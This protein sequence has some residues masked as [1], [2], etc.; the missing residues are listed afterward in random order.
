M[1]SF[2]V[3][4]KYTTSAL[5]TAAANRFSFVFMITGKLTRIIL[6][7][8]FL[9]FIFDG[10][11]TLAG[12]TKEQIIFFYL[13]FNLLDT[14]SQLFFREVYRFR[15]L[16]VTGNLDLVLVKPINPLIRVLLGG[17]D[18]L[19]GI[20]LVLILGAILIYG[21]LYITQNIYSWI[22]YFVLVINGLVISGAFYMLVL[23]LGVI[24]TS[25]DH[26]AM[27]YRD[28]TSMLRIPADLYIQP[29]RFLITFAIPLGVMLTFPPQA[30]MGILS[31]QNILLSFAISITTFILSYK[32]WQYSLKHYQSASS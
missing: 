3:W 11:R 2:K 10:T 1:K 14:L 20:V 26:L 30:L 12:Y 5:Q 6:F 13:S 17:F 31:V 24:T 22:I 23:G 25:V 4:L 27:V 9:N 8:I 28:L 18:I 21:N 7:L 19:D 32:F 15:Q 16:V 29:I